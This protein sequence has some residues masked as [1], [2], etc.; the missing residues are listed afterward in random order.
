MSE[1]KK[2]DK[3]KI[4]LELLPPE[5]LEEVAKVLQFGA[6]KYDPWNWTK[7]MDWLRLYGA[8]LRHMQKWHRGIDE[9]E[10]S[11]INHLAHAACNLLFLLW[12]SKH[13]KEL[14]NRFKVDNG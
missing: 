2:F 8:T 7:G 14:D 10:E 3:G 1:A 4:P 9:D 13:K 11:G 5:A 12:Y 6:L